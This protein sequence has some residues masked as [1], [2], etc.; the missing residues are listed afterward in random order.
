MTVHKLL[1]GKGNFVP[2]I[3]SDSTIADVIELLEADDAGA[4]VVTN[5]Q[6]SILGIISERDVVRAMRLHGPD[7]ANQAVES[8][9]TTDVVTCDHGQ[10]I[11]KILELM[12]EHQIRHVPIIKDGKLHGIINMLDLVKYRLEQLESETDALRAYV[13]GAPSGYDASPTYA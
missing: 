3:R 8:F 11:T 1:R 6:S 13:S 4:L 2:Y 9:M 10:P 7:A 5:D 12:D